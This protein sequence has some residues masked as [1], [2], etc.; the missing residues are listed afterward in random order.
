MVEKQMIRRGR[1]FQQVCEGARK[2]FLRDGYE[3]ASVDDI[4]RA[5][6]VSKATLY[7]YFPHKQLMF[8]Q[9]LENEIDRAEQQQAEIPGSDLPPDQGLPA[10]LHVMVRDA[11]SEAQI[12]AFRLSV[13]EAR[14]F[15]RHA[16]KYHDRVL[17]RRGAALVAYL[18]HWVA[19][20]ALR[21][22]DIQ[23]AAD[24]LWHLTAG[25]LSQRAALLPD[26]IIDD[27]LIQRTCARVV[28]PFLRAC[29][30]GRG[31]PHVAAAQ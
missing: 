23:L 3:G 7:S 17:S 2:I 9:I 22:A 28:A 29:A 18:E 13:A 31:V 8:Q 10:I 27:A 16:R 12:A 30:T 14:H 25:A 26:D 24:H 21:I 11:L 20:G 4:S 6:G 1:K 5:A 15:P 19:K